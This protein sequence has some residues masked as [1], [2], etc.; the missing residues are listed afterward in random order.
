MTLSWINTVDYTTTELVLF[1]LGCALWAVAYM[2]VIRGI[3]KKQFVEIPAV[4]V[5]ANI[6]WEFNWSWLFH[7]NIGRLFVLGYQLWFFLDLFINYGLWKY[8]H[9][10]VQN[11]VLRRWFKPMY[12][13]GVLAWT[14]G[15]YYFVGEGYDTPTGATSAF[16]LTVVMGFMYIVLFLQ[17]DP[18]LFSGVVGWTSFLGNALFAGFVLLVLP[19]KHF[20]GT[21]VWVTLLFNLV[22]VVAFHRR[23][24]A[25]RAQA[26]DVTARSKAA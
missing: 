8:G 21:M 7:V 11:A 16:L 20:L 19:H 9:K 10:Q 17:Q 3:V 26:V 23:R 13:V 14:V 4:A 5:M 1:G 15:L 2:G 22:Y 18:A 12:V 6:A 25:A 24:A